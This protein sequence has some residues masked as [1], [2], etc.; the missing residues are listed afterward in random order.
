MPVSIKDIADR[1]GV[2]RQ[3]VSYALTG[4]GR[5]SD[6]TR[7]RIRD[8]AQELGY[9][10]NAIA[11][12]MRTGRFGQIAML[13]RHS[14]GGPVQLDVTKGAFAA[15][16]RRDLHLVYAEAE[17]DQLMTPGYTPKV[18]R[19]LCVDGMIVNYAWDIPAESVRALRS[20]G[21]PIVWVNTKHEQ[22]AVYPDDLAAGRLGTRA[23][24]ER[25]HRRIRYLDQPIQGADKRHP[26]QQHYSV[27]DRRRGY[28]EAMVD[29]GLEPD[30]G[31][32][33]LSPYD[34]DYGNRLDVYQ[35]VLRDDPRATA[36]ICANQRVGH[37]LLLGAAGLGLDVPRDLS[38]LAFEDAGD[39]F[40]TG[41]AVSTLK[42]PM[43]AVGE[44]AVDMLVGMIDSPHQTPPSLSV[45][46]EP[47]NTSTLGPPLERT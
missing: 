6:V 39:L 22:G 10:P 25:G 9:R 16:G 23:L 17:F 31:H 3:A 7:R 42:I 47:P 26:N 24:V 18:L 2:S 8:A 33:D 27:V 15:C 34:R 13:V 32:V 14:L 29:A 37:Q 40:S 38:V 21:V 36:F 28:A 44:A 45:P 1:C 30:V 41:I 12:T 43:Q 5:L 20:P 35:R 11:R 4:S 46:Y 19:E